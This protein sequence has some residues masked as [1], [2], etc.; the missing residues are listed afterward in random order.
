VSLFWHNVQIGEKIR[1]RKGWAGT[2]KTGFDQLRKERGQSL[3]FSALIL[4]RISSDIFPCSRQMDRR[5]VSIGQEEPFGASALF[6]I[7]SQSPYNPTAIKE[8]FQNQRTR[9]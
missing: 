9:G 6:D 5:M 3:A 1:E 7:Q 8:I 2:D 4:L